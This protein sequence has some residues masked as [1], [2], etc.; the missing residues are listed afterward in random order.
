MSVK[1]SSMERAGGSVPGAADGRLT[2]VN[3]RIVTRDQALISVYDS[4]LNFGDG[5]FEGIRVYGGRVLRLDEHLRRL[6]ESATALSIEIGLA[7]NDLRLEVLRWLRANE[8]VSDFHFRPIVTRGERFPP[9]LDPR[10]CTGPATIIMVGGPIAEAA[11]P[12]RVAVASVRRPAPDAFDAKIKSLNYG[13]TLL[14]R[15]EAIRQGLDDAFLLD[16][17]G[18]LAEATTSNVFLVRGGALLTPLP[19]ACLE[20]ITRG[21]VMDLAR[22]AGYQVRERDISPA[23]LVNAEE[24]FLAGTA[25]QV[26]P[27]VEVNGRQ[28]GEGRPGPVTSEIGAAYERL[29]RDEGTPVWEA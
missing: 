19:K 15:L 23:E 21:I 8:V 28:I 11:P 10:Y 25:T 13:N 7:Q 17:A 1:E 5:V 26:T 20:G 24:V 4:G 6:Y 27:V 29:V 18:F 16:S 3:G 12:V 22:Q 14:A 9:R 2:Y